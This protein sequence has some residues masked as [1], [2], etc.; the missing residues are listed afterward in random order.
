MGEGLGGDG[1]GGAAF[2]VVGGAVSEGAALLAGGGGVVPLELGSTSV[3]VAVAIGDGRDWEVNVS[4]ETKV[5]VKVTGSEYS[6]MSGPFLARTCT[7]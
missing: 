4:M 7:L 1:V 6:P 2:V 3:L 5:A